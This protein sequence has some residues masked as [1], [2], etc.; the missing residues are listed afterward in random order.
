M[1]RSKIQH[2]VSKNERLLEIS[3][4]FILVFQTL[5]SNLLANNL[6]LVLVALF[7]LSFVF[8]SFLNKKQSIFKLLSLILLAV[9]IFLPLL[10]KVIDERKNNVGHVNVNE[11]MLMVEYATKSL[12]LGNN[13]YSIS[14]LEAVRQEKSQSGQMGY[15]IEDLKHFQ[16]SPAIFWMTVPFFI[17]SQYLFSFFDLR[18]LLVSIFLTAAYIGYKLTRGS[19]LFL[20]IFLFNP[21][22]LFSLIAGSNDVFPLTFIFLN[23]LF[24][25]FSKMAYATIALSL[26]IGFKLIALP[27]VP[28]YFSYL[29]VR[30]FPKELILRQFVIFIIFSLIIYLPFAIWNF[31]DLIS[32]LVIYQI[33]GGTTG[34]PIVGF[35]GLPQ[36]LHNFGLISQNSNFPFFVLFVPIY[37]L[38]LYLFLKSAKKITDLSFYVIGYV[39]SFFVFL[40]FSRMIQTDYIAFISQFIVLSAF[41][42][43]KK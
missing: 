25:K 38:F 9:S 41:V 43:T 42:D 5:R 33:G 8:F 22:F 16:Y 1:H 19:S 32:D 39:F 6:V 27:L 3:L 7:F 35:L 4:L 29:L 24:L 11:S 14:Y 12:L 28:I 18:L 40:V 21:V 20:I 34:K 23:L 36:L 13:P 37:F 30:K 31:W 26:A 15:E 17:L 2:V 10:S